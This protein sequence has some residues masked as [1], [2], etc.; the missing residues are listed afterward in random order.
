MKMLNQPRNILLRVLGFVGRYPL[1]FIILPSVWFFSFYPPFWKSSDVLCQLGAPFVADNVLLVPPIYCVLGRLPFWAA[2]TLVAG[3]AP[4]IFSSQHPSLWA[5]YALVACQ[6]IGLWLAI[7]YFI[8]TLSA[9][10]IARGVV[11]LLLASIASFYSFAH[12]AGAEA[13]TAITWFALFGVGLRILRGY[14]NWQ[15]WLIYFFLLYICIGSRHVSGLILGW[16]PATAMTLA[17]FQFF[18]RRSKRFPAT[19]FF[20]KIAAI[21]FVLSSMSLVLEQATVSAMCQHFGLVQRPMEGRTLCERIGSFLDPLSFEEKEKVA[22]RA[23]QHTRDPEVRLAIDS[24][25]T[26]GTYYAG[27]DT[28]IAQTVRRRGLSGDQLQAEVDRITLDAAICF[29]QTFD[30]R[31]IQKIFDDVV[32]GFYPMNDQGIA[33]TGPKA[34]FASLASIA[35]NPQDWA[36][37]SSL[38]IFRPSMAN[39]SLE[40]A[41]HDNFIRHWRFIPLGVW[42]FLFA[43][44]GTWRAVNG[45]L[46]FEVAIVALSI[47]GIGFAVYGATCAC[48]LSQPRYVLP[49]WVGIVASGCILIA[50]RSL[51]PLDARRTGHTEDEIDFEDRGAPMDKNSAFT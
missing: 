44:I 38:A 37:I 5:V 45:K 50:G 43:A 23:A 27:S 42:C 2:D 17:A 8:R 40:R 22:Q 39:A 35:K 19:L 41:Y 30:S 18:G 24:L 25:I 36:N 7:W 9:S 47:F 28:T 26:V 46:T 48:N 3:S 12:T 49:L 20:A 4:D 32:R 1:S 51:D 34:T 15:N 6:H 33:M 10:E 13:T 21:A 29:Y 16:L 14:G 31:L 11:V